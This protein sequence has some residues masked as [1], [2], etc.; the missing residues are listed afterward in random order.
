[1]K[2]GY[3]TISL[4]RKAYYGHQLAWLW[5]YGELVKHLDHKD[6]VKTN[7]AITNLRP[8]NKSKNGMNRGPSKAN[9]SGYVGACFDNREKK[10]LATITKEGKQI[11]LGYYDSAVDAA[12]AYDRAAVQY[13][14][15][16]ARLNFPEKICAS[17]SQH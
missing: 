8:S 11:R 16:F 2:N 15:E 9:T 1:M 14:G 13:H 17:P 4:D 3:V 6:T 7:N 10:W 12:L 5:M